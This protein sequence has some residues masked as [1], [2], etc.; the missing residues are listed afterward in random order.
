MRII[1]I[2]GAEHQ[3]ILQFLDALTQA[4]QKMER[5]ERIP[6]VF[7]SEAL[8]FAR[9][10]VD[11]FHHFKEEHLMFEQLAEKKNGEIDTHIKALRLQHYRGRSH[12][13]EVHHFAASYSRG[14]RKASSVILENITEYTAIVRQHI[15]TEDAVFYPLALEAFTDEEQGD[16]LA[17][18][19][20]E[21]QKVGDTAFENSRMAIVRMTSRLTPN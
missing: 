14:Q 19:K 5:D 8:E 7:I 21:D 3:L 17:L 2:L 12:L 15:Q 10:F 4:V 16:L 13:A 9:T 11:G 18:F 6:V 1:E 20:Q